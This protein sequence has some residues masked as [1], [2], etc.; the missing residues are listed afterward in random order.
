MRTRIQVYGPLWCRSTL[1]VREFLTLAQVEHEFFDIEQD[2]RANDFVRLS[3][4]G[5]RVCP[6]VAFPERI[7]IQPD[8]AELKRHLHDHGIEGKPSRATTRTDTA[9]AA[10]ELTRSSGAWSTEP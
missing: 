2:P 3:C 5:R 4:D 1:A 8:F 10:P 7:S 6:V 9:F